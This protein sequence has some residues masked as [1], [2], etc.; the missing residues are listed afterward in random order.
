MGK[1]E[2]AKADFFLCAR[3]AGAAS[4]D[5]MRVTPVAQVPQYRSSGR[6]GRL[7]PMLLH[8]N[9]IPAGAA[10]TGGTRVRELRLTVFLSSS[11]A[12]GGSLYGIGGGDRIGGGDPGAIDVIEPSNAGCGC[13][14]SCRLI[15]VI[16]AA[17]WET[18]RQR[19]APRDRR[20]L[21]G[22]D[23]S[24]VSGLHRGLG[25]GLTLDRRGLSLRP[26]RE[27]RGLGLRGL[28]V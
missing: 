4:A 6:A 25:C 13:D 18:C 7:H 23:R 2:C 11:V 17:F 15:L 16:A 8:G 20:S 24:E 19:S 26:P 12:G 10:P 1:L 14:I 3:A 22:L 9:V 28:P 5:L 21:I 27:P